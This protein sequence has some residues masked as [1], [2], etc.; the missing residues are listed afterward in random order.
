[1]RIAQIAPIIERVPPK[2]YGGTERVVSALTEELVKRGHDVTLF[3]SGDSITSA[4]LVSV[5]PRSLR[6]ARLKDLYGLNNLTLLLMGTAYGM[7]EE[8]D[9]I[10]DHMLPLSLPTANLATTPVIAT[11]HGTFT[12]ENRKLFQTLKNPAI[13]SI[14]DAQAFPAPNINHL[15]TVYNGLPLTDSPFGAVP[16]D[17]LLFV[18][19]ISMEKGTHIAIQ[20]AQELDMRLIIAA[21]LE[22][23]DRPYFKEY[24]E[25]WLSDRIEWI[26]EVDEEKRNE[27]MSKA[28]CFLHPVTWREPFGLTLIEAMACGCPVVAMNRGSIPEIV[29]NGVT[30]YVVEDVEGMAAAVEG[31]ENIDRAACREHALTNFSA[32]RMA[33]GYE[34]MYT[35]MLERDEQALP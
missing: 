23:V 11:M 31:I 4:K 28:L 34:A 6:E 7:Q 3:A 18:G 22:S 14:S 17:Y 2:R 9:I 24:V 29:Q 30:G 5:F 35:K 1:M 19:R 26:G 25:P 12:V 32:E 10:H 8:F 15:G 16:E 27:L 13:V 20:V 21:K 33:D